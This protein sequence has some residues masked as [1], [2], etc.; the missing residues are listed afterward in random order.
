[1]TQ[2]L[3]D[4]NLIIRFLVNDNPQKASRVEKLLKGSP[5]SNLL[6]DTVI[7][8]IVWV[9]S[10]YYGLDKQSVVNKIRALVHVGSVDCNKSLIDET[11]STWENNNI[12]YIDSY[13]VAIAK[14]KN[15]AIYSYDQKFDQIKTISRKE[16]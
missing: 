1:M 14:T 16:P 13:L 10:S 4:T 5:N 8:E 11:L 9:L 3:I 7:A 12:S 6:P 15:I 2:N